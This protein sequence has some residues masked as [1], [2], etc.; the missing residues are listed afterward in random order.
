MLDDQYDLSGSA[1]G[2]GLNFSSNLKP[3]SSDVIRLQL[4][5]GEGVENYMNDAPVDIGIARQ[6]RKHGR[7]PSWARRIPILGLVAFLDHAWNDKWSTDGRLLP[8]GSRQHRR[9]E[10]LTRTEEGT[11]P[12]STCS[13]RRSRT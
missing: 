1:T 9:S 5:Y 8:H 13:T 12:C 4:M 11:T 3:T 6:S 7:R 10:R 2:W